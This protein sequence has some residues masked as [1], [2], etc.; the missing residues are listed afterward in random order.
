MALLDPV[1][2]R[3]QRED[4][5]VVERNL[6]LAADFR[7][8]FFNAVAPRQLPIRKPCG[9]ALKPRPPQR[10][11][12]GTL[13]QRRKVFFADA[14]HYQCG[15]CGKGV[16]EFL[17]ELAERVVDRRTAVGGRQRHVDG[18]QRIEPEDIFC[19]DR[20]GIA[21]PVLDRRDRQL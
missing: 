12:L 13:H 2:A 3:R 17:R 5:L 14:A 15:L 20:I 8:N 21:Q 16:G 18:V 10:P 4:A 11:R 9:D 6:D 1:G 19:V 7:G